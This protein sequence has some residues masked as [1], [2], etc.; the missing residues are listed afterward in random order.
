MPCPSFQKKT[1]YS[2]RAVPEA[3]ATEA[4]AGTL[5]VGIVAEKMLLGHLHALRVTQPPTCI[6]SQHLQSCVGLLCRNFLGHIR[7]FVGA[8]AVFFSI[9]L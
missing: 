5:R 6:L 7:A 4:V 2:G 3:G 8:Y 1:A 9:V